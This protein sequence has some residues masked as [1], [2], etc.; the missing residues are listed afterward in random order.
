MTT[1]RLVM[2]PV[3]GFS[4]PP[5]KGNLHDVVVVCMEEVRRIVQE[6]LMST[7]KESATITEYL[8]DLFD[9]PRKSSMSDFT[10]DG[11]WNVIPAVLR[12][13]TPVPCTLSAREGLLIS[14]SFWKIRLQLLGG[15]GFRPARVITYRSVAASGLPSYLRL[16]DL[17]DA[18][19]FF[20]KIVEWSIPREENRAMFRA[21]L[22][23]VTEQQ[24]VSLDCSMLRAVIA[25]VMPEKFVF[26]I[27][28]MWDEV[29]KVLDSVDAHIAG[30]PVT[31]DILESCVNLVIAPMQV[32]HDDL[33]LVCFRL[34]HEVGATLDQAVHIRDLQHAKG[35]FGREI[36]LQELARL[37]SGVVCQFLDQVQHK[38]QTVS[39]DGKIRA[40]QARS[41]LHDM[42]RIGD[43]SLVKS[44]DTIIT[45]C[46][47]S[48][49]GR[50]A[51]DDAAVSVSMFVSR[52]RT[53]YFRLPINFWQAPTPDRL[54]M[55][56]STVGGLLALREVEAMASST[57]SA[58]SVEEGSE[59]NEDMDAAV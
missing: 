27:F 49:R 7:T 18:L 35:Q 10:A 52:M 6:S 57:E 38:V 30:Q 47:H 15:R 50:V 54:A 4:V 48:G 9:A 46:F 55:L 5:A 20:S 13:D 16:E 33:G 51:A 14:Q 44:V 25:G 34:W 43:G 28:D 22:L 37:Y 53:T 41:I 21:E 39:I 19:R 23:R 59:E 42:Y 3:T 2:Q 40:G 17:Q 45:R 8:R 56:L 12:G 29:V 1:L 36:L 11:V 32:T 24:V 58:S 26:D 31:K